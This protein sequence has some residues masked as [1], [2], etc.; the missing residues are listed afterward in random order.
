MRFRKSI[1][2]PAYDYSTDGAYFVTICSHDRK[3]LFGEVVDSE[4]VLNDIGNL[5]K[6]WWFKLPEKYPTIETDISIV[7]PNHFHGI[8]NIVNT[9]PF[10]TVGVD[11]CVDPN[12]YAA[13]GVDPCVDPNIDG[14]TNQGGRMG[15]PLHKM[16]QWFKTMTTNEYFRSEKQKGRQYEKLWQRNYYEHII[17]NEQSLDAIREYIFNNPLKWELDKYYPNNTSEHTG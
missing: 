11:P 1:R 13:V 4:T 8:I 12:Q 2:L 6:F 15:P 9:D 3:C 7:M 5:I 10:P 16:I 17:R 14:H